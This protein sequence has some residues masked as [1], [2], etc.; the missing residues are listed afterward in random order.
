[1]LASRLWVERH[2]VSGLLIGCLAG[3]DRFEV[4]IID[5]KCLKADVGGGR[6][7]D[8]LLSQSV[9]SGMGSITQIMYRR[10]CGLIVMT[11]EG[12]IRN[13]D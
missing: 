4:V 11:F 1:M 9:E 10:E 13:Y 12:F 3:E 2:K 6:F 5:N 8:V 7:G